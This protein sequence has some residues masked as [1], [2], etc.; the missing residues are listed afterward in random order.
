MN[1]TLVWDEIDKGAW[2]GYLARLR[3]STLL[4]AWEYG[5]AMRA[6]AG[7][8]P[9][10]CVILIDGR[11]AGL[12]QILETRRWGTLLH[13]ISLDRGPLW[14]E[15]YGSDSHWQLFLK[16]LAA[17]FPKRPGRRYRIIPERA[18]GTLSETT[19]FQAA[20]E[21][22]YR[23]LWLDLAGGDEALRAGLD[24]KWR[25]ALAKAERSNL[26]VSWDREGRF[27]PWL[28]KVYQIDKTRRSYS[29]ATPAL[30][31][32]LHK[33]GLPMLAGKITR[34]G[35]DIAGALFL[36]HGAAAT[37]QIGWSSP[38]GRA[39]NAHNMLLWAALQALREHGIKDLDLG[40]IN[41]ES[42][43]LAKFKEGMGGDLL[44]LSG[45]LR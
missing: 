30:I 41:D 4:Q 13:R 26:D 35:R 21:I 12:A 32:K 28:L 23:T 7:E 1:C 44:A 20:E 29:G 42:E 33:S 43:G 45:V 5:D 25:N 17:R 36:L 34:E 9:R 39:A 31:N 15:G 22:S 24:K 40:G 10:R 38:E 18:A 8:T 16:A 6:Y 27:L 19:P 2:Q 37:Y 14:F 3:R 11:E